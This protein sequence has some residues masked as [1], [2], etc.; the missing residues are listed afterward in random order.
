MVV[1][2]GEFVHRSIPVT[3]RSNALVCSE[4]VVRIADSNPNAGTDIGLLCLMCV[5]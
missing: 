2:G 1:G 5:V 4:L 3:V